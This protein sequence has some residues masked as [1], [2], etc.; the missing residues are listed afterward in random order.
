MIADRIRWTGLHTCSTPDTFRVIWCVYYIYI[1]FAGMT[2]FLTADT[3]F[4]IYPNLKKGY[5]VKQRVD[6]AKRADPL[7]EWT[8]KQ[9]T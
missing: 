7:T 2:A 8:V 6:S 1:H 4:R 3:F 5:S 9:N